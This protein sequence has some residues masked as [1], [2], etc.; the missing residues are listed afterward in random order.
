MADAPEFVGTE[1]QYQ[2]YAAQQRSDIPPSQEEG[3]LF[4]ETLGA[5]VGRG[6]LYMVPIAGQ[7]VAGH[8]RNVAAQRAQVSSL[9]L[10]AALK[11]EDPQLLQAPEVQKAAK[12]LFGGSGDTFLGVA[13]HV[14]QHKLDVKQ[15][16]M[17]LIM[18]RTQAGASPEEALFGAANDAVKHGMPVPNEAQSMIIQRLAKPGIARAT[19]QAQMPVKIET[20]RGQAQAREDVRNAPENVGAEAAAGAYKAAEKT[21]AVEAI[22]DPI[23]QKRLEARIAAQEKSKEAMDDRHRKEQEILYE[24]HRA[25][26]LGDKV[27]PKAMLDGTVALTFDGKQIE[28]PAGTT[29]DQLD[30]IKAAGGTLH[31][32]TW[33]DS[34]SGLANERVPAPAKRSGMSP[35]DEADAY[36]AH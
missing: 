34:I 29:F 17:K 23:I 27:V 5:K 20:T 13:H 10:N 16:F 4:G 35:S 28:L 12:H 26:K 32:K 2:K 8:E 1:E 30:Q 33:L 25:E 15:G 6:L 19:A 9:I 21:K 36:F 7:I 11:A 14:A 22:K 24:K 3:G 18:G 31:N